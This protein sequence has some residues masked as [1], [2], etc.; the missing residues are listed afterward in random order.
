MALSGPENNVFFCLNTFHYL[1]WRTINEKN[2][3]FL[4]AIY[5]VEIPNYCRT[6]KTARVFNTLYDLIICTTT[7]IFRFKQN[8]TLFV[9]L[10]S[11][12][13]PLK[14]FM[15][16]CNLVKLL[17]RLLENPKVIIFMLMVVKY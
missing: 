3:N 11:H 16:W 4:E 9:L 14:S 6:V 7:I 13:T 8:L 17:S 2:L 15:G 12:R 10:T 1:H 5:Y